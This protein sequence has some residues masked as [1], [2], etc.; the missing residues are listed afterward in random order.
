MDD[1]WRIDEG[2][3]S[4]FKLIRVTQN[5][6]DKICSAIVSFRATGKGS[7]IQVSEGIIRYRSTSDDP[8]MLYCIDFVPVSV[9]KI[10]N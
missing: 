6:A 3:I 1:Y 4:D 7:G 9:T 2:E 5:P 8:T 10:G